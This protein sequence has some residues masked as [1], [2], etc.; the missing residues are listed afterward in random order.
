MATA[1]LKVTAKLIGPL[2]VTVFCPVARATAAVNGLYVTV[3]LFE[4]RL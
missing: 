4:A 2:F 3:L 1:S